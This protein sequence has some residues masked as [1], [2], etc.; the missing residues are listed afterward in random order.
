M[1]LEVVTKGCK[2]NGGICTITVEGD[3]PDMVIGLDAKRLALK[4]AN[5]MGMSARG[6]SGSTGPYS[7]SE[8]SKEIISAT[9]MTA[10]QYYKA[11][12]AAN[13]HSSPNKFRNEFR[14]VSNDIVP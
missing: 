8:G 7:V 5:E 2:L 9:H 4:T 10:E 6:I 1:S 14:V 11:A 13:D 3:S 12:K